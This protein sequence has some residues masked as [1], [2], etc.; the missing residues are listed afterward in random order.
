MRRALFVLLLVIGMVVG[1]IQ[2]VRAASD[3]F[4]VI[5]VPGSV[6]TE[7]RGINDPGQIVGDYQ[8]ANGLHGFLLSDSTF[9]LIDAP[10]AECSPTILFL[11]PDCSPSASTIAARSWENIL[12]LSSVRRGVRR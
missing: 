7:A 2:A 10:A 9:T 8:D 5:D 3:G 4:T 12:P 11:G 1:G 6:G